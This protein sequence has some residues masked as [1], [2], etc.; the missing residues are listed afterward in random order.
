MKH[1]ENLKNLFSSNQDSIKK[2]LDDI[3]EDES[4]NRARGLCNHI[5]WQAGHLA[6]CVDMMRT[7][8]NGQRFLDDAWVEPFKGGHELANDAQFPPFSDV[9]GN[10]YE[11][12]DDLNKLLEKS[13]NLDFDEIFEVS[14]DWKPTRYDGLV[15]F[16]VHEFYHAGQVTI[17]RK[18]L[19]RERPFG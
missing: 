14:P 5:K 12:Y 2:L 13:D 3:T 4:M 16:C 9:R 8:L 10:L 18:N 15:F 6:Y 17:V 1:K 11:L 19:G 7:M